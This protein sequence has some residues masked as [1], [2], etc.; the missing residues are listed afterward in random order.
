MCWKLC[1]KVAQYIREL[2]HEV[3]VQVIE[4]VKD[5][6]VVYFFVVDKFCI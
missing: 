6:E 4:G 5:A 2:V 3:W 1:G